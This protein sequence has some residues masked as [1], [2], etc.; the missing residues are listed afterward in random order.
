MLVPPLSTYQIT[1]G[2]IV[3][4]QLISNR[5][6][7]ILLLFIFHTSD[8]LFRQPEGSHLTPFSAFFIY[9]LYFFILFGFLEPPPAKSIPPTTAAA[10]DPK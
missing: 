9:F 2:D 3:N 6:S 8:R 1:L 10:I 7:V 5:R 4:Y